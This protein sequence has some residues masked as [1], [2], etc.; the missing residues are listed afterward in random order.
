M[1]HLPEH[2]PWFPAPNHN[3]IEGQGTMF[4]Q[5]FKYN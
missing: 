1:K 3:D 4:E 5:W 2:P